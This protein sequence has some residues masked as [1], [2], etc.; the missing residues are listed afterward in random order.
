MLATEQHGF[1][2]KRSTVTNL[3]CF[4][5]FVS[6]VIDKQGQVDVVYTDFQ[7]AFDQIDYYI[8]LNKLQSYG[9]T[10]SLL[11]LL[12]SYLLNRVQFVRYCNFYSSSF[13][14]TSGVPQ[15]SN[16]G[17]LL[18]LIFINDIVDDISCGKLLFAD[19]MKLYLEIRAPGDSLTLQKNLDI[20][21]NWCAQN[22]L[23]LNVSKCNVMTF[24][25]K[26]LLHDYSLNGE[27][28]NR[29]DSIK[30]LGVLF[31]Q[32]FYF[33]DH[34]SDTLGMAYKTYGFIYRNC[35]DF[36]D[37]SVLLLLYASLIRSRLEYCALIWYPI[38]NIHKDHI[39]SL[40]RKFLKFISYVV[41]GVYP[42]IGLDHSLLLARFNLTTLNTRRAIS[43]IRFLYNLVNY[44]IDC[45]Y[46]LN[47]LSFLVPRMCA[48]NSRTFYSA[49]KRT[50]VLVKSPIALMMDLF[51]SLNSVC[52][53]HF[54]SIYR[55]SELVI[56]VFEK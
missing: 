7:K 6:E 8:L 29:V 54:D 22:G 50:N 25:R 44:R 3:A 45:I 12:E 24:S 37:A 23:T 56:T 53:I 38:Y 19:D 52:D 35:K 9:F 46:L 33:T 34:I 32:K 28:I 48:R 14:P 31:D 42:P 43:V 17:P 47:K 26:L 15:G 16:L 27:V 5:Q 2:D 40:Q 13:S 10:Q 20:I 36:T 39:E 49:P 30:D 55:I 41:D 51:N 21:S 11:S 18:F 4:S 1:V